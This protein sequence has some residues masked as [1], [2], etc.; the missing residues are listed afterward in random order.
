[1]KNV[2]SAREILAQMT[3]LSLI[4]DQSYNLHIQGMGHFAINQQGIEEGADVLWTDQQNESHQ[5]TREN[6]EWV[7]Y[8]AGITCEAD[9][10]STLENFNQMG[11]A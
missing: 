2:E 11:A 3:M 4:T 6:I 8:E 7:L 1:M 10:P 9:Y 5:V